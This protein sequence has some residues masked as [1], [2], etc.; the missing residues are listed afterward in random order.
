MSIS[1]IDHEQDLRVVKFLLDAGANVLRDN[2]T[3]AAKRDHILTFVTDPDVYRVLLEALEKQG[4]VRDRKHAVSRLASAEAA[5][6]E[7]V[8]KL[9]ISL[10]RRSRNKKAAKSQ[11]AAVA[12]RVE[13]DRE[14]KRKLMEVLDLLK[15]SAEQQHKMGAWKRNEKGLWEWHP[16]VHGV[17]PLDTIRAESLAKLRACRRK[18][19]YGVFDSKWSEL[20]GGGHLEMKWTKADAFR[21]EGESEDDAD[22]KSTGSFR[23]END[24]ELVGEDLDDM[25]DL[26]G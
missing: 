12:A 16:V 9:H 26:L 14:H 18:Y 24:E 21:M 17:L 4:E 1:L 6:A 15:V 2:K 11:A 8:R 5:D 7:R 25:I 22:A 20:T 19:D 10:A 3:L 13:A 23:D